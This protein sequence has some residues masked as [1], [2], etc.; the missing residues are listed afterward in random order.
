MAS[1]KNGYVNH[2]EAPR[3]IKTSPVPH[4]PVSHEGQNTHFSGK[5]LAASQVF[6]Y[7]HLCVFG[8]Q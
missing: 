1:P 6:V 3:K 4:L 5:R 8:F 7:H 2:I